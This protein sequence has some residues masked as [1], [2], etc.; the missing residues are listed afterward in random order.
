M[1]NLV[2]LDHFRI[3]MP[4]ELRKAVQIAR[5]YDRT[6]NGAFMMKMGDVTLAVF[7]G[8]GMGWDH[9]SVSTATRCPTWAEME[10]VARVFFKDDEVAMQL[11]V[12]ASDHIN[13]HPFT[14][15]WWRPLSKLRKIPLPPKVM[16]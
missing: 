13:N 15:H 6:R 5:D 9:I 14:L 16:V 3:E 2:E 10:A 1:K 8:S 4:P 7:A 12:P 11:H